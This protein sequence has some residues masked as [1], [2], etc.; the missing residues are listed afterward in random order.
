MS[1]RWLERPGAT[2]HYIYDGVDDPSKTK[3]LVYVVGFGSHSGD[4]LSSL[5][6]TVFGAQYRVL[7]VDNR[8]A[9][10]SVVH[11]PNGVTLETMAEDVIAVMDAEGIERA[12]VFGASMGG[13]ISLIMARRWPE[14]LCSLAV[15]VGFAW[16]ENPSRSRFILESVRAMRDADVPV[17]IR[18]RFGALYLLS[19]DVFRDEAFMEAWINAPV[20][21][22][23][24]TREGFDIQ[25]EAL[26]DFDLRAEL[27]L[28]SVPTLVLSSPD[29]MIV[30]PR[31]QEEIAAAIPNA[32]IKRYAGGHLFMILPQNGS[33]F[34]DD[35]LAF[36]AKH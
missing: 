2:L 30:P 28:I 6:R 5:F 4:T 25:L 7:I 21:P 14:R 1:S 18:N 24:Q 29:D 26:R 36:W 11:A 23:Q 12:H 32:Q 3:T 31:F 34:V 20:D 10:R 22:L 27:P 9:G 8:G 35:L 17:P 33:S 16:S 19:E 15:V 13:A